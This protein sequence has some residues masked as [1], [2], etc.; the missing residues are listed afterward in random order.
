M[1]TIRDVFAKV[2]SDCM[3]S[4]AG[5]YD[6]ARV[7]GYGIVFLGGLEFL[8]LSAWMAIK[9]GKF[10]GVQFAT[11]LAAI[12]VALAAAAGGVWLKRST[13]N[14]TTQVAKEPETKTD[15]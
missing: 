11:G 8:C 9:D 1:A 7:F 12:G 6:P 14:T 3:T 15:K 2:L 4:Q 13:E 10:D 5:D